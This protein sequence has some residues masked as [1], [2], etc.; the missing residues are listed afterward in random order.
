MNTYSE[1][2][3]LKVIGTDLCNAK[4]EKIQ[5]KGPST[6]GLVWY[7]E[8][9]N[10]KAFETVSGWGANL[11]RLAMYTQEED[12]YL[13]GGDQEFTKELIDKGV[14]YATELSMYVI[15][16]WHILSDGNPLDNMD[17]AKKFFEEMTLKYKDYGNVIY[18]ICNEPNGDEVTWPV[19]KAYAE[20]I[21][22]LIRKNVPD[23][24]ILVGT[25]KWSQDV[26]FA[27]DMPLEFDNVMY[28]VHYYAATH[29]K[30]LRDKAQY[31]LNKGAAVFIDE[32]SNCDASGNGI[33]DD[34]EAHAWAKFV[35]EN[36]LSY[37]QWNLSNRDESSAMVKADCTKTSDWTD[38]DLTTTGKWMVARL[39]GEIR[40]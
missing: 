9:I 32:Y 2:G 13:S 7:P 20:E 5:L 1:N 30:E 17:E 12:G 8:Y 14:K 31:A 37:A 22:P 16:D 39:A 28:S 11:I 6:L 29:K 36:N 18:E 26:N 25:P 38:E 34:E 35:D 15:I 10:K 3:K 40:Y 24:V 33:I 4:G 27:A 23:A 19:V 21:I